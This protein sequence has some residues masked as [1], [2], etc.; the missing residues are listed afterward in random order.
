[1]I[2][3]K[4]PPDN[5]KN[6]KR[7]GTFFMVTFSCFRFL[8]PRST[9]RQRRAAPVKLRVSSLYN[10][11]H[12][13]FE[14]KADVVSPSFAR[15]VYVRTFSGR[16]SFLLHRRNTSTQPVA[17]CV[18]S[19]FSSYHFIHSQSLAHFRLGFHS[20]SVLLIQEH[21]RVPEVHGFTPNVLTLTPAH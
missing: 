9:S 16:P 20:Q 17:S 2:V 4:K 7:D 19:Q 1:M 15:C 18:T 13:R 5:K 11:S 8:R 3:W 14:T 21:N 6:A 10:S 12:R